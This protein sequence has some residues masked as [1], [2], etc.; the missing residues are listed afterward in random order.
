MTCNDSTA[1]GHNLRKRHGNSGVK[2]DDL[3]EAGLEVRQLDSFGVKSREMKFSPFNGGVQLLHELGIDLG[4]LDHV[5]NEC[6]KK[7]S[8]SIGARA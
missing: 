6:A 2:T 7:N 5:I 1:L 4:V 8:S 3:V